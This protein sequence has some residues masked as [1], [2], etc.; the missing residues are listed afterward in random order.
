MIAYFD[1]SALIPLLVEEPG[2]QTAARLWDKADHVVSVRLVYAEARVALA[3]ASRTGRL[4]VR[5]LPAVV[6]DLE[7]LSAHLDRMDID[8]ALVR[9]AGGLA[10][11]FAL[12]GYD[13]VHLAGAERLGRE[14]T[15]LVAGDAEL[16]DA[17]TDL[18]IAVADTGS[19]GHPGG[20]AGL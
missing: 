17:A 18:G 13:A 10:Q 14:Q 1:T 3:Q 12:R 15:V 5:Q 8:E 11:R 2:S 16:C 4:T 20:P 9:Q 19:P 7:G 6:E